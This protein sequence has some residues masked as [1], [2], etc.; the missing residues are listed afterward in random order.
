MT[1]RILEYQ[2]PGFRPSWLITSLL[3][4]EAF[5][6]EEIVPCYH[7]RWRQ[8]THHREWKY[9][10]DLNNLRSHSKEG[11][12]KEVFVQLNLNNAVRWIT[13]EAAGTA[14]RPV[15]L[16]FLEAKRLI[17][18]SIPGMA[19]APIAVLPAFYQALLA[20]IARQKI[21]VRPGRRYPRR[22]DNGP[23]NKGN[24]KF[25]LPAAITTP[26]GLCEGRAK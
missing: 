7:E 3:D 14:C 21:L 10:F 25:A 9:T 19:A 26:V 4:T 23:R 22:F 13:A 5:P 24:G 1:V 11:I 20:E 8:E 16:K 18:A 17:V 12:L 2:I 6:Y 15:D